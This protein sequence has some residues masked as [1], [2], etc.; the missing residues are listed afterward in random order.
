MEKHSEPIRLGVKNVEALVFEDP[1]AWRK[2][3]HM[4]RFLD[5]WSVS[6]ISPDLRPTGRAAVLDF[7][8]SA[9]Q[10]V[11]NVL[12]AHFGR[13]VTIDKVGRK[14]VL[15]TQFDIDSPPDMEEMSRFSGMGSYRKGN[16]LYLTFWR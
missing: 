11:E 6:R 9:D 13:E 10:E 14:C 2:M 12:S 8:D 15:N 4:R 7:L 1:A 5:Q 3:P 16:A